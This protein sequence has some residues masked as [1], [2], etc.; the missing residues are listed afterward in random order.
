M[1]LFICSLI[2]GCA[3]LPVALADEPKM[4]VRSLHF[5]ADGAML[6][7]AAGENNK[8]GQVA[9]WDVKTGAP[10][11]EL[12]F[13]TPNVVRF[14]PDGKTLAVAA[15]N[16]VDFRDV[17]S[18]KSVGELAH[19]KNVVAVAFGPSGKLATSSGDGVVRVWDMKDR[20]ELAK[21]PSYREGFVR[22]AYSPDGK[23]LAGADKN[24]AYQ[25]DAATGKEARKFD[26]GGMYTA[27]VAFSAD[28]ALLLRCVGNEGTIQVSDSVT[29]K[30]TSTADMRG[31]QNSFDFAPASEVAAASSSFSDSE[32]IVSIQMLRFTP[33]TDAER[34][35]I[36]EL[37]TR[38]DAD[39]IAVREAAG[40]GLL[41]LGWLVEPI[42]AK[43]MTESPSA[44]VRLRARKLRIQ[45][46][47]HGYTKIT[48]PKGQITAIAVSGDGKQLA[49]GGLNGQVHLLGVPDGK[50]I[51]TLRVGNP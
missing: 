43:A 50:L 47:S 39:D 10:L 36:G 2:A 17:T 23:W 24:Q 42:L 44:E 7:V 12:S 3:Y 18:G 1:R 38:L 8:P 35:Q 15:A 46:T 16:S 4:R 27:G 48:A 25:W 22:L 29:G 26:D 45:L 14:A 32:P 11:R 31:G 33:P 6:A 37:L 49:V 41:R 13:Q 34:Q 51:R 40:E 19:P 21:T 5:S 28:G 20:Q 30:L 9:V